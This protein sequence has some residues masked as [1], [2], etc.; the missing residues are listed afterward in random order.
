MIWINSIKKEVKKGVF[1]PFD[2]QSNLDLI[3]SNPS[4]N[5]EDVKDLLSFSNPNI[6]V[7]I[8]F[9]K[10]FHVSLNYTIKSVIIIYRV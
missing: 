2:R 7:S 10:P 5:G 6:L 1:C 4:F 3:E 8:L 9:T